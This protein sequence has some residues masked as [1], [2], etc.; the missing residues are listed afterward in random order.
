MNKQLHIDI[1]LILPLLEK[2][3]LRS[4]S[5]VKRKLF[6]KQHKQHTYLG[7]TLIELFLM[8]IR[9]VDLI[10]NSIVRWIGNAIIISLPQPGYKNILL[11]CYF[12]D[13]LKS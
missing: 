6:D 13:A 2:K 3:M 9:H 5:L 10:L 12:F 8:N 1:H 4:L 7:F 11:G